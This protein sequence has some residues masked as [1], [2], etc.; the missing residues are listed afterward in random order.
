MLIKI[1]EQKRLKLEIFE[2]LKPRLVDHGFKLKAA[3]ETFRR[4]HDGVTDMFQLIF[5]DNKIDDKPGWRIKLSIAVRVE[6]V[7]EI[8]HQTSSFDQKY[9]SDTATIG[10]SLNYLTGIS[11]DDSEFPVNS[12][13]EVPLVC[14][15]IL[16][17]FSNFALFYFKRFDVLAE[18]DRELNTKPLEYNSNR[19]VP[20]FRCT[21]GLIV[22]K[23]VGRADYEYLVEVY[24]EIMRTSDKGFYLKR[25]Q[26]LVDSLAALTP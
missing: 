13:D 9:Q 12:I 21:T 15:L 11:R 10:S 19:G 7:E 2:H 6:K 24:T 1:T 18:I 5:L 4:Q 25:F 17:A 26:A 20:Y 8:F 16:D 3:K 14:S 23:L 22:A